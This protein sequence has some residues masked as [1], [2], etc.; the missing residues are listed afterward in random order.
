M[1]RILLVGN[2]AQKI[3]GGFYYNVDHKLRAAF[4]RL[5]HAV[6]EFSDRDQARLGNIFGN[7]KL[8]VGAANK[9][10]LAAAGNFRPDCILLG[11]SHIITDS[12]LAAIRAQ[13][14]KIRIGVFNV[15]SLALA[16]H[17]SN[18]RHLLGR[19]EVADGLFI[20]TGGAL[21][22]QFKRPHNFAAYLPNPVD[23]AIEDLQN[24]AHADLPYDLVFAIG[25]ID[26]PDDTRRQ[27][28][29]SLRAALGDVK[30]LWRGVF[31][32]PAVFGRPYY[33]LLA[34]AKMG[35]NFSRPNDAYWYASDRMAHLLGCGLLTF[36]AASTGFQ[37]LFGANEMVFF[38]SPAD[39]AE[40]I[41][42][43]AQHDAA[44]QA[45]AK[46][47]W[48]KAHRYCNADLIARYMLELLLGQTASSQ[49]YLWGQEVYA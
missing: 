21:L 27:I 12:T 28:A 20:S 41:R 13:W 46:A 26:N 8:G 14:P 1:A 43:Y 15:D 45:I 33:E 40:K 16:S 29:L 9:K 42:H 31:D 4:L 5:G 19:A 38:D 49:G 2:F 18:V 30:C 25:G 39:L 7:R 6:L 24:F 35:L 44:R 32:T 34:L 37:E 23:P 22:R 36:T 10:L 48:E 47:G 3:P 11:H 17:Q